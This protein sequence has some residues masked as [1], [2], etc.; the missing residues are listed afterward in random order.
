MTNAGLTSLPSF[1]FP[2]SYS[3][4]HP[5]QGTEKGPRKNSTYRAN[6]VSL[7]DTIPSFSYVSKSCDSIEL[8]TD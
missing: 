7:R 1:F 4:S 5:W 2:L 3:P 8:P 6:K